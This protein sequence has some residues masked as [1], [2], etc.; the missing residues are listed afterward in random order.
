MRMSTGNPMSTMTI[1]KAA[2]NRVMS[3]GEEARSKKMVHYYTLFAIVVKKNI[4]WIKIATETAH[5][6]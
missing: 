6:I 3:A 4:T 1:Q 5:G 2:A